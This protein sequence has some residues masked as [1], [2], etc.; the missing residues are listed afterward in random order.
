[1][2][3]WYAFITSRN[4]PASCS[5]RPRALQRQTLPVPVTG[6]AVYSNGVLVGGDGLVEPAHLPQGEA[7]VAQCE[8]LPEPVM[9]SSNYPSDIRRS[10]R[11]SARR[12]AGT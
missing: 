8:G 5:T 3:S 11:W 1:M 4:R 7:E 12:E 9:P 6:V 2:A 10:Q